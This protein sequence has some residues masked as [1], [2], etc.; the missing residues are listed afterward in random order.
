MVSG[1]S[2]GGLVLRQSLHGL[3]GGSSAT[4]GSGSGLWAA[5]DCAGVERAGS[6]LSGIRGEKSDG[7]VSA[8]ASS[9]F[10]RFWVCKEPEK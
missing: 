2:I 4:R 5:S 6:L 1:F 9:R 8:P 3:G 10:A 7:G